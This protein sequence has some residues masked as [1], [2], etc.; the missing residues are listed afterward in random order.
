MYKCKNEGNLMNSSIIWTETNGKQVRKKI[1]AI[2]NKPFENLI[3]FWYF[4]NSLS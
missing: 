4:N 3:E 2:N 1:K